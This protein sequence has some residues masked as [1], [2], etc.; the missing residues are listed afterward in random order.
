MASFKRKNNG[1]VEITITRGKRF[2]GKP[3]RYY[4]EVDYVS[5]KQLQEAAALF[6][7]DIINGNVSTPDATSLDALYN[8]FMAHNGNI[9]TDLK[10][11]TRKRYAAIYENQIKQ[12]FG[13]KKISKITK[14]QIRD[15]VKDL[16]ENGKNKR[17]NQ[18]LSPKT[19][20]NALSLLSTL[21][22]YAVEDLELLEKNP[23]EHVKVP[24]A[25]KKYKVPKD[26]YKEHEIADLISLLLQERET[27]SGRTHA[28]AVLLILFTGMRAGEV[29]GLRWE[30]IDFEKH[31]ISI[32]RIRLVVP[33]DGVIED[34][35]KTE[36]SIRL[37]TAPT[38]I[39]G[40]LEI[41]K[42]YQQYYKKI[43]TND[44]KD[45]GY[46]F[47]I[48]EGT[49]HHPNNTY[50][51]FKRFLQKYELKDTTLHDLRHTH[52]AILSSIG[53]QIVDVS[54]RLGH[55]NTRITQEVYEYY[56]KSTDKNVSEKLDQFYASLVKM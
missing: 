23:C 42:D 20:K 19:I 27:E 34:T 53:V 1:K 36:G 37:I 4:R 11:S 56:F 30:D 44:Y 22:K 24:K 7:A 45:S 15:W 8:D 48:P 25:T 13:D 41:L 29:M 18:P 40:I 12:Y 52:A 26:F 9:S 46:V 6:L 32:E 55:T 2:D 51:W 35:P 39:M 3:C 33:D 54:K 28:T 5:E 43:L 10:I 16:S 17:T 47:T 49:P 14:V 50:R 38:F 21:F 31:T